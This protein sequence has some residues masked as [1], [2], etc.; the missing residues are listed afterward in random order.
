MD[1]YNLKLLV[2]ERKDA[3]VNSKNMFISFRIITLNEFK[4]LKKGKGFL[5]CLAP[6]CTVNE[7]Q[8]MEGKEYFYKG[9][10]NIIY[11]KLIYFVYQINPAGYQ[12]A[13]VVVSVLSSDVDGKLTSTTTKQVYFIFDLVACTCI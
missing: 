5:S 4:P 10:I 2:I 9:L 13:Q 7:L 1:T 12:E 3:I 11:Q 6:S 8:T